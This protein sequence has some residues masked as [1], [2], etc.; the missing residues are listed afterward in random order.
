MLPIKTNWIGDM[1][2]NPPCLDKY[3]PAVLVTG[4]AAAEEVAGDG[5]ELATQANSKKKIT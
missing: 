3:L 1:S 2:M 4:L 5:S